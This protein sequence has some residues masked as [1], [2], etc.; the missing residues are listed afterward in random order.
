[1][2]LLGLEIAD[3]VERGDRVWRPAM[4]TLTPAKARVGLA[5]KAVVIEDTAVDLEFHL[6]VASGL[7]R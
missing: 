7:V 4:R 5:M 2:L 3:E 6:A 1:M